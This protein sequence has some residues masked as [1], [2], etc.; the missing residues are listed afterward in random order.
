MNQL[1]E[2]E[3]MSI[4]IEMLDKEPWETLGRLALLKIGKLSIDANSEETTIGNEIE[5]NEKK[6][7]L[8][9]KFTYKEIK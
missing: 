8:E 2:K 9:M 3:K 4:C 7:K 6:Y 5:Y 1:T